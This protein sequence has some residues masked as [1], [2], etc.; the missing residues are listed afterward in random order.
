MADG[1]LMLKPAAEAS[2]A[3]LKFCEDHDRTEGL[4]NLRACHKELKSGH[5]DK[6]VEAF[7]R[8]PLGGMG[9]FADWLP[10]AKYPHETPEYV[11]SV[12][13]ALLFWFV[14]FMRQLEKKEG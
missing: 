9:T 7:R 1:A 13:E 5:P 14:Y 12:F 3:L 6:A 11:S 2:T 10:P 8:I 4:A